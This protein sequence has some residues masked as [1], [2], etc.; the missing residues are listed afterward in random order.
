METIAFIRLH[1]FAEDQR[2]VMDQIAPQLDAVA[3]ESLYQGWNNV[4]QQYLPV[5][6]NDRNWL[7]K[8]LGTIQSKHAMNIVV[9]DYL[10]AEQIK[11]ARKTAKKIER[12][13]FIPW[14]AN[15]SFNY[16][17]IGALEVEKKASFIAD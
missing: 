9:L 4:K 11:K 1:Q 14:I 13:G 5:S 15:P 2:E 3:A 10:P 12:D 7:K 17:G 8:I 16:M 6:K